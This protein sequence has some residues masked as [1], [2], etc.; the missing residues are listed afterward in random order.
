[1]AITPNENDCEACSELKLSDLLSALSFGASFEGVA[2]FL[3][4]NIVDRERRTNSRP[5]AAD[6]SENPSIH[7]MYAPSNHDV[8]SNVLLSQLSFWSGASI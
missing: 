1:M 6:R 4:D 8:R 2:N 3:I 5:G 7:G